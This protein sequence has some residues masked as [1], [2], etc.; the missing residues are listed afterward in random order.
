M[1]FATVMVTGSVGVMSSASNAGEAVT[2]A[3]GFG[4]AVV[5]GAL[6]ELL[7]AAESGVPEPSVAAAWLTDPEEL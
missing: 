1:P 5:V 4:A 3:T 2:W 7:S 6:D